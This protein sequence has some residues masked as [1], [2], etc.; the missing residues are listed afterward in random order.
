M[1]VYKK[2]E[3]GRK[4]NNNKIKRNQMVMWQ[5]RASLIAV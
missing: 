1:K 2:G 4:K 5:M 3:I